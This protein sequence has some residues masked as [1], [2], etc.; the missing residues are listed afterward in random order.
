MDIDPRPLDSAEL[1]E[2][3]RFLANRPG[4]MPLERLDGLLCSIAIGPFP[5]PPSEWLPLALGEDEEDF[6]SEA[7]MRRVLTLLLR[8]YNAVVDGFREDWSGMSK[9]EAIETMYFPLL[10]ETESQADALGSVWARGFRDGL[11]WLEDEHWNALEND[12]E[13]VAIFSLI[14]ALDLGTKSEGVPITAEERAE[15][16][17]AVAAALQYIYGFWLDW[18]REHEHAPAAPHRAQPE[19]GRNDPCTCGSGQKYKKCCGAP[20]KL[21]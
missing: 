17:P 15:V 2:L 19:P 9:E 14:T 18:D 21:H 5:I 7:Q 16:V 4:A 13:C 20:D 11:D 1:G 8:H 12:E 3:E 6:E 10:D